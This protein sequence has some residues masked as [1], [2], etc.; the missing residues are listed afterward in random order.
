M[1]RKFKIL[2]AA[3]SAL[4]LAAASYCVFAST[5]MIDDSYTVVENGSVDN[6]LP[7]LI[8]AEPNPSCPR[9]V[10]RADSPAALW[11]APTVR[12]R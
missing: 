12:A 9:S 6:Y 10:H 3:F 2:T 5:F 8:S 4:C 1:K 11:R 7:Y